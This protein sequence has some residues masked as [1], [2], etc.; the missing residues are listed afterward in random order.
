MFLFIYIILLFT[1][2]IFAGK[3]KCII[4]LSSS[5]IISYAN[6][7]VELRARQ[8]L[9]STY[10]LFIGS[11]VLQ[12]IGIGMQGLAFARFA[13]DGVGLPTIKDAGYF[14]FQ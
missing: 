10:R 13:S 11:V 3:Y 4:L 5:N 9:H 6:L 2:L 14:N 12:T 8:L 1:V 7:T